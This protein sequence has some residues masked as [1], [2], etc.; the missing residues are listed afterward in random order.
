VGKGEVEKLRLSDAKQRGLRAAA[1]DRL[2][3]FPSGTPVATTNSLRDA[4]LAVGRDGC[5][6]RIGPGHRHPPL[7]SFI[8]PAGREA[9]GAELPEALTAAGT[10]LERQCVRDLEEAGYTSGFT[11]IEVDAGGV[12]IE[13]DEPEEGLPDMRVLVMVSGLYAN[14]WRPLKENDAAGLF[15]VPLVLAGV[16]GT[17]PGMCRQCG[18]NLLYDQSGRCVTDESSEYLCLSVKKPE[19]KTHVLWE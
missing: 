14:G 11:V 3:R 19:S 18:R 13:M 12:R 4:G 9:I 15:P 5:G 17:S 6:H 2:G 7:Y 10:E 8:T 16:P 1:A